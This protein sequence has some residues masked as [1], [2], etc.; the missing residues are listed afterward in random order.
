[1]RL[2]M[3]QRKNKHENT[4]KNKIDV[5][6][7]LQKE[8]LDIVDELYEKMICLKDRNA[9]VAMQVIMSISIDYIQNATQLGEI[10]DARVVPYLE[11]LNENERLERVKGLLTVGYIDIDS[12]RIYMRHLP[13]LNET[14]NEP[15]F[16]YISEIP[17][18]SDT[19]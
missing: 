13:F 1:M 4:K 16:P 3:K 5:D 2:K 17:I 9:N 18:N 8:V 7:I 12:K 19:Q 6:P 15:V 10:F 14:K 11:N